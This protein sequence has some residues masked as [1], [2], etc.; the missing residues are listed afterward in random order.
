MAVLT[1]LGS[2]MGASSVRSA[3]IT[4]VWA[5]VRMAFSFRLDHL[6]PLH[7]VKEIIVGSR[8]V[9]DVPVD[10]LAFGVHVGIRDLFKSLAADQSAAV[11]DPAVIKVDA[12]GAKDPSEQQDIRMTVKVNVRLHDD[13]VR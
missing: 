9:P 5:T 6:S 3:A 7:A 10:Q 2:S 13:S 1:P 12:L 8:A 4:L 11:R